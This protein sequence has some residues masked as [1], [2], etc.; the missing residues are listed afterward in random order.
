VRLLIVLCIGNALCRFSFLHLLDIAK[1]HLAARDYTLA[2]VVKS[3]DRVNVE[4]HSSLIF[5]K[6]AAPHIKP[7]Q[8][9]C[10]RRALQTFLGGHP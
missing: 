6:N 8:L 2:Q 9:S 1:V 5:L 4:R 7:L 10:N 3:R